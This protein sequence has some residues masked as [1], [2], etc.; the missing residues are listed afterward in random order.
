MSEHI[1]DAENKILG[2]LASEISIILQGKDSSDYDPRLLGEV[3]VV[4]KNAS[5]VRVTGNNKMDQKTYYRHSKRPGKLKERKLK[6]VMAKD[7]SWAL[8]N[9][10]RLMLPKNRLQSKRL[11]R[12]V[13][14]N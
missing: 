10:V 4:V 2:R 14:E 11:N 8:R 5:K 3:K 13:I 1:I 6:E 9:A 12:L 7:P